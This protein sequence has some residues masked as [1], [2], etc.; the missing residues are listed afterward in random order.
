M[1]CCF[2][3]TGTQVNEDESLLEY[4]QMLMDKQNQQIP[5]EDETWKKNT[6]FILKPFLADQHH[7][8]EKKMKK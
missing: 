6:S 3:G 7:Q 1:G 5:S 2:F 4:L 8:T